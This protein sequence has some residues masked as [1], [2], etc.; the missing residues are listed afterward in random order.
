MVAREDWSG[1]KRVSKETE[2]DDQGE[3]AGGGW[4][5]LVMS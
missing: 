1:A 4:N 5:W 3:Y 2:V